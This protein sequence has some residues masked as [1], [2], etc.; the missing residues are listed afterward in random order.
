MLISQEQQSKIETT[1]QTLAATLAVLSMGSGE[2]TGG[3]KKLTTLE[4]AYVVGKIASAIGMA[5]IITM[6]EAQVQSWIAE[7]GYSL[8][9]ED[10][11]VIQSLREELVNWTKN[12]ADRWTARIRTEITTANR[13]WARLLESKRFTDEA[14]KTKLRNQALEDL[15]DGIEEVLD[16]TPAEADTLIQTQLSEFFQEGQAANLSPE[17]Y[18]Y[19]VPRVTACKYCLD[20]HLGPDG[21]PKLFKLGDVLKN[22][23]VGRRTYDW[24]FTIGPVHP[25]CYC[26]LYRASEVP[27]TAV[28][29]LA[30]ARRNARRPAKILP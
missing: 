13:A 24:D 5:R 7:N 22:S 8:S 23:N 2:Q 17:E 28:M 14:E 6:N 9:P 27:P 20:L 12:Q 26:V 18:V 30:E 10:L 1:V 4:Q 16:G 25:H 15:V 3:S 19:K 29:E 11:V 21:T